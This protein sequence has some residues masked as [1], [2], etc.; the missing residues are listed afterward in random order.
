[1]SGIL[2]T[3]NEEC[4]EGYMCHEGNCEPEPAPE[5][6][7]TCTQSDVENS[8]NMSSIVSAVLF[9]GLSSPMAYQLTNSV[10]EPLGLTLSDDEGCP[11]VLGLLVHGAVYTV[12]TR[13]LMD[14][15]SK[16]EAPSQ[17]N[18]RDKWV[19]SA[20]GGALF[21]LVSSPF[22]YTITNSLATAIAGQGN[23][24]ATSDGC[25]K[26]SGLIIHTVIFGGIV[27]VMMR[28]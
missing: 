28:N 22:M 9:G 8:K 27:R 3:G 13:V 16:C 5:P 17:Y 1:M 26:I 12:L 15:L 23:G 4:P 25:P 7:K 11:T 21:I 2:C 10:F 18:N 24:I 20:M 14:H 19:T 6:Q